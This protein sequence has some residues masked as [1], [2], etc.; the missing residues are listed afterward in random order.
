MSRDHVANRLD[1]VPARRFRASGALPGAREAPGGG[2]AYPAAGPED[3]STLAAATTRLALACSRGEAATAFAAVMEDCFPGIPYA[4]Y[5]LDGDAGLKRCLASPALDP[6]LDDRI[7]ARLDEIRWSLSAQRGA[8]IAL[9][10]DLCATVVGIPGAHAGF[11]AACL[12]AD[13]WCRADL[14]RLH[15]IAASGARG[16]GAALRHAT[17]ARAREA[18]PDL[19]RCI[20]D[21]VS[22]LVHV[23]AAGFLRYANRTA[24]ALLSAD[25][26][27]IGQPVRIAF[28]ASGEMVESA[29]AQA[30]A[31]GFALIPKLQLDL[32]G[33]VQLS[34]LATVSPL[35][36]ASGEDRGTVIQLADRTAQTELDRLRVLDRQRLQL[37]REA[38]H[39][40]AGPLSG[41]SGYLQLIEQIAEDEEVEELSQLALKESKRLQDILR[42][43]LDLA[44]ADE[45]TLRLHVE[46]VDLDA[47]LR[48]VIGSFAGRGVREIELLGSRS[49]RMQLDRRKV[50][51]VFT[52]LVD[53][54]IKYSQAP[55]PVTVRVRLTDDR[56]IIDV[57]DRG[58]GISEEGR[59]RLFEPFFREE[60]AAERGI[61]GNGLG[62]SIVQRIVHAHR[63]SIRVQSEI[64]EGSTFS[65]LLPIDGVEVAPGF[66]R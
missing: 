21:T 2:T 8:G 44:K 47:L 26:A 34:L 50:E 42:D 58:I 66:Q 17:H 41:I 38:S 52:N 27:A 7:V 35:R 24:A 39:E 29:V 46:R 45:G 40:I 4:L 5:A 1:T 19:L 28:G 53:N 20:L 51:R 32:G 55:A 61:Q 6:T 10:P 62:L 36:D 25:G 65:V 14:E 33:G 37:V 56:A 18:D 13:R 22:A 30:R 54:A 16:L 31:S 15:L 60:R 49:H 63:G 64:G 11:L 3:M 12:P 59:R 43:V 23:D 57:Q 9:D 48:D